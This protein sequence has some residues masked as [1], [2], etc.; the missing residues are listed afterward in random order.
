MEKRKEL[1][2][3]DPLNPGGKPSGLANIATDFK[4]TDHPILDSKTASQS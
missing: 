4:Y 3:I 2:S 1:T